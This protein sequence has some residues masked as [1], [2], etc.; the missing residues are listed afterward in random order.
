MPRRGDDC[1]DDDAEISG[2]DYEAHQAMAEHQLRLIAD[3]GAERFDVQQIVA[4]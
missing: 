2:I 1:A 4:M 3:E